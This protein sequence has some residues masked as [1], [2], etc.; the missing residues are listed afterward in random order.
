MIRREGQ[1][2]PV[3][4]VLTPNYK[5]AELPQWSP[6]APAG[7]WTPS[8]AWSAAVDYAEEHEGIYNERVLATAAYRALLG[9][10][11]GLHRQDVIARLHG[12]DVRAFASPEAQ[13]PF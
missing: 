13:P 9:A 4:R 5:G 11:P 8:S 6:A 2:R 10:T 12:A 7:G 3:T 1:R